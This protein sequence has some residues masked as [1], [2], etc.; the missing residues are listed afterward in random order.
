MQQQ[1]YTIQQFIMAFNVSR[2]TL[3]RLWQE[4]KGP[5]TVRV[6][7]RVLIAAE[8]ANDW[9]RTLPSSSTLL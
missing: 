2:S 5:R 9:L 8:A 7:R 3:Y 1:T 6:K 4:G